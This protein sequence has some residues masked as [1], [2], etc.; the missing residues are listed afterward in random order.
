MGYLVFLAA[1]TIGCIWW[2]RDGAAALFY[3]GACI[4]V[5]G[6]WMAYLRLS[7]HYASAAPAK[8]ERIKAIPLM[9]LGGFMFFALWFGRR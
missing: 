8:R 7:D 9:V 3:V 1:G 4:V 2:A 6:C 5:G